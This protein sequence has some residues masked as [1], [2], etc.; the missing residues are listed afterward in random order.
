MGVESLTQ[1]EGT[2]TTCVA[3]E[4]VTEAGRDAACLCWHYC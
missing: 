1:S 4:K 2:M 3:E